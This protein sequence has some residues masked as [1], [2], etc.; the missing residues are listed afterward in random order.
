MLTLVLSP[1]IVEVMLTL[2][3]SPG[4]IQSTRTNSSVNTSLNQDPFQ[5]VDKNGLKCLYTNADSISNKWSELET[6]VHTH[7]LDN[8]NIGKA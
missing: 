1:I 7:Q 4:S 2:V 5:L 3:L 8:M 6:L